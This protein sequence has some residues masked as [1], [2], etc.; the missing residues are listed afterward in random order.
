M[1]LAL[2]SDSADWMQSL[3]PNMHFRR[4]GMSSKRWNVRIGGNLGQHDRLAQE[5][6]NL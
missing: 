6:D 3:H 5:R 2:H 1:A 4:K